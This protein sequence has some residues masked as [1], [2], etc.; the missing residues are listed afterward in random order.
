MEF[1]NAS[2]RNYDITSSED[3]RFWVDFPYHGRKTSSAGYTL[4]PEKLR[5]FVT[6][7]ACVRLRAATIAALDCYVARKTENLYEPVEH[8]L[9]NLLDLKPNKDTGE[10]GFFETLVHHLDIW[11]NFYAIKKRNR[12]GQVAALLQISNPETVIPYYIRE[13]EKV[14]LTDNTYAF[15]GQLVYEVHRN[16]GTVPK[17]YPSKDILHVANISQ[18]GITGL[19]QLAI[20][21]EMGG[22]YLSG[23][24][25]Q[26][27]RFADGATSISGIVTYP[28]AFEE[29]EEEAIRGIQKRIRDVENYGVAVLDDDL[30][31]TQLKPMPLADVAFLE[32]AE[33][34]SKMICGYLHVPPFMV[35]LDVATSYNSLEAQNDTFKNNCIFPLGARISKT[36]TR[37]LLSPRDIENNLRV[38]FDYDSLF[39]ADKKARADYNR[40]MFEMGAKPN[41]I[42]ARE[43]WPQIPDE[44]GGNSSFRP[45][46]FVYLNAETPTSGTGANNFET[47]ENEP[48]TVDDTDMEDENE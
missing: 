13:N 18:N 19:S 46:N 27:D 29:N 37:A 3:P 6:F 1:L 39:R 22:K 4:T 41:T 42:M 12:I 10:F 44:D 28:Q 24:E 31:F 43:N 16:D 8:P 25:Y 15:P 2:Y 32:S 30:Q 48:E 21:R 38:V 11:G 47:D 45:G 26:A 7:F 40:K 9:N 35:G 33:L 17:I 36:F 20:L 34:D 14:L 5:T 23:Q